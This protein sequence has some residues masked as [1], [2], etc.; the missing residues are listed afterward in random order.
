[1]MFTHLISKNASTNR[2]ERCV[3]NR[4]EVHFFIIL[5]V[6]FASFL[7]YYCQLQIFFKPLGVNEIKDLVS[8][9]CEKQRISSDRWA[10]GFRDLS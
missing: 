8:M 7:M 6:H 1:M 3:D 5:K 9:L 4:M 2:A 10:N